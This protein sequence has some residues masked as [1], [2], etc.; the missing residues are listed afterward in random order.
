MFNTR[1]WL[2]YE[3]GRHN[4]L[5]LGALTPTGNFRAT[6][7]TEADTRAAWWRRA[8]ESGAI[9]SRVQGPGRSTGWAQPA[10]YFAMVTPTAMLHTDGGLAVPPWVPRSTVLSRYATRG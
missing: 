8:A 9:G 7:W 4:D 5:D 3:A 1:A 2:Y 6:E 10:A